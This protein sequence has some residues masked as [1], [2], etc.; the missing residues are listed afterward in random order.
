M[1]DLHLC[2]KL[3]V[4]SA[5]KLEYR[6]SRFQNILHRILDSLFPFQCLYREFW[7]SPLH[8]WHAPRPVPLCTRHP[9]PNRAYHGYH[10]SKN[11]LGCNFQ[12][13]IET[14]VSQGKLVAHFSC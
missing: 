8:V 5:R 9:N 2:K 1:V 7:N 12:G 10:H 14:F 11:Q 3:Q 4:I 6:G 13:R